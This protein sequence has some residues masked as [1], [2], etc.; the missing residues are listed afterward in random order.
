MIYIGPTAIKSSQG[1]HFVRVDDDRAAAV[2][3]LNDGEMFRVRTFN[4]VDRHTEFALMRDSA[5]ALLSA[6]MHAVDDGT[7]PFPLTRPLRLDANG[8]PFPVEAQVHWTHVTDATRPPEDT[9]R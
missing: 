5:I 6:L 3:V 9:E 8:Q 7:D 4:G 1:W 2:E